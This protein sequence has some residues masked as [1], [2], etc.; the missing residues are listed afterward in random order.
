MVRLEK[1]LKLQP[2]AGKRLE[3]TVVSRRQ[4]IWG[5]YGYDDELWKED[6]IGSAQLSYELENIYVVEKEGKVIYDDA[7]VR[8]LGISG[9]MLLPF[10][11]VYSPKLTVRHFVENI[12][13]A[14]KSM[15]SGGLTVELDNFLDTHHRW[16]DGYATIEES[17][18][19]KSDDDFQKYPKLSRFGC[20]YVPELHA[21]RGNIKNTLK[22]CRPLW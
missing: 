20:E 14:V 21:I 13:H 5:E 7:A 22:G 9:S 6:E 10:Q 19:S 8:F 11:Y 17:D 12:T 18:R 3:F 2:F 16:F 1:L 15:T 4:T